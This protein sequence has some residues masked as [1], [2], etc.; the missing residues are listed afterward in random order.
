MEGCKLLTNQPDRKSSIYTKRTRALPVIR[1]GPATSAKQYRYSSV[2]NIRKAGGGGS[3]LAGEPRQIAIVTYGY[4]YRLPS[5][6]QDML[7]GSIFRKTLTLLLALAYSASSFKVLV[8]SNLL[9][10]SFRRGVCKLPP[11]LFV[12]T[13]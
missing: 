7:P 1:R 2:S 10:L 4:G 13:C 5:S 12:L 6:P 9:L 11:T 3:F 8:Y